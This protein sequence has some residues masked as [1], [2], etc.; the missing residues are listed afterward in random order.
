VWLLD[1]LLLILGAVALVLTT[2]WTVRERRWIPAATV[3]WFAASTVAA[4]IL[5]GPP[6]TAADGAI[7]DPVLMPLARVLTFVGVVLAVMTW[8]WID[9]TR[10]PAPEAGPDEDPEGGS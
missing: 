7:A 2:A 5:I 1:A 6:P 8:G 10:Q 3:L 4:A 9:Y